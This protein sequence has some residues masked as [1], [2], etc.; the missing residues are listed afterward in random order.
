MKFGLIFFALLAGSNTN[1][2]VGENVY[3]TKEAC[4]KAGL[5]LSEMVERRNRDIQDVQFQCTKTVLH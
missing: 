2:A 5:K 4:I 3:G 1:I